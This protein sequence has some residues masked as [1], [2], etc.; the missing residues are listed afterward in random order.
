MQSVPGSKMIWEAK[1][2][3]ALMHIALRLSI[4]IFHENMLLKKSLRSENPSGK[5]AQSC[6]L[7]PSL[8]KLNLCRPKTDGTCETLI[9]QCFS[10]VGFIFKFLVQTFA[11]YSRIQKHSIK[12]NQTEYK[13]EM[14][15]YCKLHFRSCKPGFFSG[16][17]YKSSFFSK[18]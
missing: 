13:K 3:S 8:L 1:C 17:W 2:S 10:K 16:V 4:A 14:I 11:K 9:K 7:W 18:V 12:E 15:N 6:Y 5:L